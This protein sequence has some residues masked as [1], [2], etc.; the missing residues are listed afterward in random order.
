CHKSSARF[1]RRISRNFASPYNNS[2][3]HHALCK[4][5]IQLGMERSQSLEKIKQITKKLQRLG[6]MKNAIPF[7]L[8]RRSTDQEAEEEEQREDKFV[9]RDV[10]EGHLA[11][12]AAKEGYFPRRFVIPLDYLKHPVFKD[13]LRL[14]EE[15]F[16]FEH[17]IGPL[18][19]PCDPLQ[20]EEIISGIKD[21]RRG[22]AQYDSLTS[23]LWWS[24]KA[25][26]NGDKAVMVH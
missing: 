2:F 7:K 4:I 19:I 21:S 8:L 18:T 1:L 17:R 12:Y 20:L 25:H 24:S 14:A 3:P 9:P 15:E 13:L 16:G 11:I 26:F 23:S 6:S 5:P 22:A 10:C